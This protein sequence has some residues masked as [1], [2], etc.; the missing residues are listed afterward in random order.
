MNNKILM[1]DFKTKKVTTAYVGP[2]GQTFTVLR[3]E[4]IH[5]QKRMIEAVERIDRLIGE[6][7]F[8]LRGNKQYNNGEED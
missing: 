3:P 6:L 7:K 4:Q 5:S 2:S 8:N 1:V